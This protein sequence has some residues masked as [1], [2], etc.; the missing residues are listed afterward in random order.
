VAYYL[1]T[2]ALAKLIVA[3]A[4]SAALLAWMQGTGRTL[5]SC[6]LTRTELVRAVRRVSPDRLLNVRGVLETLTILKV[7]TAMFEDAGLLDPTGLRTLDAIHLT[8]ARALGD[9]LEGF[10]AYDT[11]LADAATAAGIA[12]L[13]P[14]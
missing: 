5:V 10:V 8:A 6:D 11:R 1:D 13:A 7:S 2:S 9:D 14:A 3:E 12:V 4:E